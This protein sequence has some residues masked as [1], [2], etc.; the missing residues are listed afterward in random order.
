[1]RRWIWRAAN[2]YPQVWRERYGVE[3]EALLDA[4]ADQDSSQQRI[5]NH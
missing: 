3:F 2:L 1:M 4:L 5:A